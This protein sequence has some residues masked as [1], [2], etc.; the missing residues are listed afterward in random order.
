MASHHSFSVDTEQRYTLAPKAQ[1][2]LLLYIV[3]GLVFTALGCFMA[4]NHI[5]EQDHKSTGISSFTS[6]PVKLG[7][8]AHGN[9]HAPAPG[10]ATDA[11][12]QAAKA[13]AAHGAAHGQ[14][15]KAG[16]GHGADQNAAHSTQA[17]VAKAEADHAQH[18]GGESHGG[19]WM[20]RLWAN[21]WLNGVF[22][23]GISVIGLFFVALQYVTQAGWSAGLVRIPMS[24]AAWIPIGLGVLL[25]TFILGGHDIFHWTHEDLYDKSS[26]HY[27]PILDGKHGFLNTPFFIA[28]MVG[29]LGLWI[30]FGRLIKSN[31]LKED[32]NPGHQLWRKNHKLS[33]IFLVTF[34]VGS[35]VLAWDWLMS[36]EPHWYSTLFGWYTFASWHVSGFAVL[37]LTLVFL[38]EKGLMAHVNENHLHD[39]GKFMFGLSIFWA[40]LWLSQYLLIWYANIPEEGIYFIERV[41][42]FD[43]KYAGLFFLNVILNFAFPFLFLMTRDAKRTMIFLKIAAGGILVGHWLDFYLMIM[44]GTVGA[45]GGFGFIEFGLVLTFASAF[46]L[47]ISRAIASAPLVAKNHPMLEESLYHD[48]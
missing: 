19:G 14:E 6:S 1:S 5:G 15:L 27:D 23:T 40:Y 11:H 22:F 12:G 36:V 35:S 21:L 9:A 46:V 4:A 18:A 43:G 31:S 16:A 30:Y 39:I 32:S 2:R 25:F 41:R 48:I 10:T 38:K 45:G 24:F 7:E 20:Q 33:A 3:V 37:A 8:A 42:G 29:F 47:V 17:M 28:R 44:P 13:G 26:K 34:A